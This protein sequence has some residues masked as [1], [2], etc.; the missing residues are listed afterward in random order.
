MVALASAFVR[1][2][3]QVDRSEFSKAGKE[4]GEEAGKSFGEG[5][6][7]GSD[8]RLR[9]SRGKF[10]KDSERAGDEAGRRTGR[11]FGKSLT[12][13]SGGS[14]GAFSKALALMTAKLTLFGGA[15]AAATP[16]VIQLTAALAPAAGVLAGLPAVLSAGGAALA[17]FKVATAGVGHAIKAG[18]TGTAKQ[19]QKALDALPPS[20][21]KFTKVIV[22]LKP[23][24][25]R[26]RASVSE[27]FFRPLTDDI[28]PLAEKYFPVLRREMSNLAGPLGGLA[29]QFTETA[30]RSQVFAAVTGTFKNT[31]LAVINLRGAI[32]PLGKALAAVVTSTSGKLPALAQGFTD[33]A[34]RVG[35]FL[36]QAAKS[37]AIGRF[38]QAGLTTLK[39]LGAI[40]VNVGS[41]LSSVF[42]AATASGNSLLANLQAL[43]GQAAAFLKSVQG[44]SALASVFG[45][46]A[47][48]GA[49]LRTSL[50]A[51]LPAIAQ[52]VQILAPAIAG[53][54]TPFSQLVVALAPLLPL[55]SGWAA[56]VITKLTPAI[57]AMSRFL[58]E[59][60]AVVK[61]AAVAVGAFLVVQKASAAILAVQAAGGLL[62]Y[63]KGLKLVTA[64][65]RIWA[66]AQVVLDAALAASGIPLIIAGVAAL[67]AGI[68]LL[69]RNNETFRKIVQAVWAAIKV[70]VK[71]TVDWIVNVAW[72]AIKK[73][74]DAIAAA[75][76][77][78]WHN[79]IQPVWN[80]IRA[81]IDFVVAA[82]KLYIRALVAEFKFIAGIALWLWHNIFEPVFNGI[83]K[84]VE[85]W[86]LAV[87]IVFKLF[88]N[89]IKTAVINTIQVLRSVFTAVFNYIRDYVI[90]PWWTVIKAVFGALQKYILGPVLAAFQKVKAVLTA[91][92]LAIGN[93]VRGWY[94]TYIAPAFAAARRS[95]ELFQQGLSIIWNTKIKP[96]FQQFVDFIKKY[97]VGGFQ[98]GVSLIA[99]A[100]D[101][102]R[103]AARKPVEFVVNHIINPFINGLNKA[104]SLV[105]VKDRV[106]P[107]KGF[108][109][110]GQVPGYATGGK[111]SGAPSSVDNRL[112]PARIPGVGA[113]KLAGGEYIVNAQDTRKALPL[114]QWVNA[115]MKGGAREIGRYLGR[116]LANEPGD[117]SEGWAFA[118]GGLVG[119]TKDIWS[120][121]TDPSTIKKPFESLLKQIPGSGMIK[122]FLLGSAKRLLNGA[123]SWLIG[124]SGTPAAGSAISTARAVRARTFVQSQEGKPYIWASAGPRGYD[125][126][127][128]V[129]AA[130]NILKGG[131]P[132]SH[133]FSTGS[134]PG[135]WFDTGRK[136]GALVAGW[137]HPGQRPASASVGH[138]AGMVAGMPFESTGSSGVRIGNRARKVGAFANIGA[139][140]AAGGLIGALAGTPIRLFDSGG[141][142]P[143]G[144]FGANMSGRTE[145]VDPDGRG[146]G[147]TYIINYYAGPVSHPAEDGRIIIDRIKAFERGSGNGWRR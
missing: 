80:G 57:T 78:L 36:Q 65:T 34:T 95:W 22:G 66:A 44:S 120:A 42:G 18:L 83:K 87:Q 141:L 106:E 133:T 62:A 43:T 129:S 101:K 124:G 19:A 107:I 118:D 38:F 79:V 5:F 64:A 103:E 15:A 13:A 130:Y 20:A 112:A 41:I 147:N 145:Y 127:G 60:A 74:W 81:V 16:G 128:I 55:L 6:T 123:I 100:W 52:S 84:V 131:N 110:G 63:V 119:W 135:P 98:T 137:S 113:V 24:I 146:G 92:F 90:I 1:V 132:Y 144:T 61:A 86:W 23:Q 105:G 8:G 14:S 97:V 35:A 96:M 7:R 2:R 122:D 50:G 17:T 102:V 71:A 12:N 51:V 33:L 76:L 104:A 32:D 9:D 94:N 58:A 77:W 69:Y 134:L 4:G 125:C 67:I 28:R 53:L 115:G 10:V 108:A 136:L 89:I 54:A 56:V 3:P 140:R 40:V 26:L 45:T 59:H 73:A 143:S 21:Q 109:T 142:W 27:Q 72:P 70:A 139:A 47:Q 138:M 75:A 48:F 11:S 99:K 68:I 111:I 114:L 82:V 49:A 117:G 25:D 91:L 39:Q 93:T 121:I 85:I 88:Y 31:R 116:P 29:E 37:G 126:S 46:L 30:R